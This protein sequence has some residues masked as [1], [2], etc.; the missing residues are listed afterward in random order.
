MLIR[1]GE[2]EGPRI[3]ICDENSEIFVNDRLR[4]GELAECSREREGKRLRRRTALPSSQFGRIRTQ[5]WPREKW[6]KETRLA[7]YAV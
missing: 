6:Q 3:I 1:I 5:S 4:N 7:E 2:A